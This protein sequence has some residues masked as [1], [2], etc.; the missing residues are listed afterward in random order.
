MGEFPLP[1]IVS[2]TPQIIWR[3]CILNC[4]YFKLAPPAT[5]TCC[6]CLNMNNLMRSFWTFISVN[7]NNTFPATECRCLSL[8]LYCTTVTQIIFLDEA[9]WLIPF[10]YLV[11][12]DFIYCWYFS[13][14]IQASFVS[15]KTF[16]IKSIL[17]IEPAHC[18]PSRCKTTPVMLVR[19][20]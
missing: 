3:L 20:I 10:S 12:K 8:L 9:L 6:W 18:S 16:S 15:M 17:K 19:W 14:D 13:I 11:P 5:V 4:M 7:D 2:Q 1:L